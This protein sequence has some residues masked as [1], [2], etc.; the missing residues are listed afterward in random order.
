M[1]VHNSIGPAVE[2]Q[3][4]SVPLR[5]GVND[6]LAALSYRGIPITIVW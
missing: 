4:N 5:E 1:Y 3:L 2:S 6:M